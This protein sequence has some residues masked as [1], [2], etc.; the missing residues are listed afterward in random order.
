M[1]ILTLAVWGISCTLMSWV[2]FRTKKLPNKL[3]AVT[4]FITLAVAILSAVVT[5]ALAELFGG[6]ALSLASA[7]VLLML[8]LI[9]KS[10]FG[11]G[12]V[13]FAPLCYLLPALNGLP[14]LLIAIV[15]SFAS[16]GVFGLLMIALK[17]ADLKTRIP[18]GPFMFLS[19]ITSLLF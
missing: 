13:K 6:A 10:G 2:D 8:A 17:R 1:E 11:L 4:T 3:L 9:A 5:G 15:L 16:A 18:F 7:V 12:D 14:S 19:S